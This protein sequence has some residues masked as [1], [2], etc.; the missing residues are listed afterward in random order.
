[1]MHSRLFPKKTPMAE[2]KTNPHIIVYGNYIAEQNIETQNNYYGEEK[3]DGSSPKATDPL[4]AT[5]LKGF[6]EAG[7]LDQDLMPD[8][9]LSRGQ[10]AVLAQA[11][12]T[13]LNMKN[14]WPY[15]EKKWSLTSLRS[16]CSRF[17]TTQKYVN[18][19]KHLNAIK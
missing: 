15:F 17:K 8:K 11:I 18:F 12:A 16:D 9:K 5:A 14:Y 1:M 4:S 3:S 7:L 2:D 10:K 6:I 13:R 19:Q